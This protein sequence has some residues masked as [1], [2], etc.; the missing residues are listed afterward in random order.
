ME[1]METEQAQKMIQ[2]LELISNQLQL[3]AAYL[4]TPVAASM[5]DSATTQPA[6]LRQLHQHVREARR[7]LGLEVV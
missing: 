2:M 6:Y 7:Q 4:A 3:I 1:T 5:A